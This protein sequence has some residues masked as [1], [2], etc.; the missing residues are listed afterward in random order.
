MIVLV[1]VVVGFIIGGSSSKNSIPPGASGNGAAEISYQS[2]AG[3]F[4]A[5]LPSVPHETAADAMV[6]GL[7]AAT[8]TAICANSQTQVITDTFATA[9]VTGKEQEISQ[10]VIGAYAAAN[11][12]KLSTTAPTTFLTKPATTGS[13]ISPTEQRITVIAIVY[14]STRTYLLAGDEGA[15]VN[16]LIA[17]F[18]PVA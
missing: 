4:T 16:K 14:S 5:L 2:Q 10:A 3:H 9:I 17:G 12:L 1:A 6:D 15:G 18:A 7:K 13:L 8:N 11:S